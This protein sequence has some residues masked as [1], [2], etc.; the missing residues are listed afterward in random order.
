MLGTV[1]TAWLL[2]TTG[3]QESEVNAGDARERIEEVALRNNAVV[4]VKPATV[5]GGRISVT[6]SV[7]TTRDRQRFLDELAKTGIHA[8]AQIAAA[9]TSPES[10]PPFSIKP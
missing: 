7:G 9:K 1:L 3:I 2:A 6:G 4:E 5:S 8:T 10:S